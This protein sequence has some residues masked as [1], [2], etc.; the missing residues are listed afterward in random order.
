MRKVFLFLS[1]FLAVALRAQAPQDGGLWKATDGKHINAHGGSIIRYKGSYLWYGETRSATGK[2]IFK[3][4][5]SRE[6]KL[7]DGA[8]Y[9]FMADIWKP[10]ELSDSRHLWIPIRF[11]DGQP[12][13]RKAR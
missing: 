5:T 7:F 12:V 1:L 4:E 8:N 2:L 11:E 3:V 13:L 9:V 6:R 10:K